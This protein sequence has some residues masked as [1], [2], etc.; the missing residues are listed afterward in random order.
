MTLYETSID[1]RILNIII[2]QDI[3]YIYI[4][5][6]SSN[7]LKYIFIAECETGRYGAGCLQTCYCLVGFNCNTFTGKCGF[8]NCMTG[9]RG[10]NCQSN[11]LNH[12]L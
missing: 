11:L 4:Y 8:V 2:N 3:I 10:E 5:T 12:S 6:H 9:W 7:K 1:T